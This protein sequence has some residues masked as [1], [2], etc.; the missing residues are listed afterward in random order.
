MGIVSNAASKAIF[1]MVMDK[2]IYDEY[3]N[4]WV[5]PEGEIISVAPLV[6]DYAKEEL[7]NLNT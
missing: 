1:E 6:Y 2:L 5:I 7:E 3:L 4:L